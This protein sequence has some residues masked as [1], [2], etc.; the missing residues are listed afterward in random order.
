MQIGLK[1]FLDVHAAKLGRAVILLLLM[2]SSMLP[3]SAYAASEY[4]R[5]NFDDNSIPS[6]WTYHNPLVSVGYADNAG[7]S[8]GRFFAG[9][10]SIG[11]LTLELPP[12]PDLVGISI[13][14]Q[15]NLSPNYWGNQQGV[16]LRN[17]IDREFRAETWTNPYGWGN[18]YPRILFSDVSH[19]SLAQLVQMTPGVYSYSAKFSNGL[20]S[21]SASNEGGNIFGMESRNDV[22]SMAGISGIQLMVY[23]TVGEQIWLDN[24]SIRIDRISGL[25]IPSPIANGVF[26]GNYVADPSSRSSIVAKNLTIVA[27][28]NFSLGA[29]EV[30]DLDNGQ[31]TLTIDK[32]AVFSGNGTIRGNV[33]NR[34]LV[35]IPVKALAQVKGSEVQY[36]VDAPTTMPAA[37]QPVAAV[38]V[39]AASP[40][41]INQDTY[42]RFAR[43]S[44]GCDSAGT[45][46][47]TGSGGAT[48][49]PLLTLS[50]GITNPQVIELR[51][52]SPVVNG[53]FAVDA[54]LSVTGSYTQESTGILR[55]FI[56]GHGQADFSSAS[57]SGGSYSQ[58]MV[59]E[60]VQLDGQVQVVLQPE[61]FAAFGYAPR[62]GDTFD[63]VIGT[64]GISLAEGLRFGV[65]VTD[66]G[67]SK[68]PGLT[69]TG[70]SS[71]IEGD[72]DHLWLIQ[73]SILKFSLAEG[74]T[75]LRGTLTSQLELTTAVPEPTAAVLM[76]LGISG[77]LAKLARLGRPC[78]LA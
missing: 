30:I 45:C 21:F 35:R 1:G 16:A 50:A 72:P 46:G 3:A 9:Y 49:A 39:T 44:G 23:Q 65:L 33:L 36:V 57:Q 37:Q 12:S 14:W 28:S 47:G 73:N 34:G 31:G 8:G 15:A 6:G 2:L 59:G 11:V 27:E 64:A 60:A 58:L 56:A 75:V 10:D 76:L 69:M 77:L 29:N 63:F 51:E 61:L 74:G 53:T 54:S 17:T 19:Y 42:F 25:S 40:V 24:V 13:D 62:Q 66:A 48:S 68:L 38:V 78:N 7:I 22:L 67:K 71:P 70:Y 55:L 20:T 43:W 41:V 4:I 52:A 32:G 5:I 18:N 26:S